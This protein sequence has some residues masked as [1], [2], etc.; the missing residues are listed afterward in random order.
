MFTHMSFFYVP[1]SM[2]EE[3][4]K[5]FLRLLFIASFS[6]HS[7]MTKQECFLYA[8][9]GKIIDESLN[10]GFLV[11]VRKNNMF[12]LHN[13]KE[14]FSGPQ[15]PNIN[16]Q[17]YDGKTV[18]MIATKND[19]G[20]V[21][22]FLIGLG[23][24][25]NILDNKGKTALMFVESYTMGLALIMANSN[26]RVQDNEGLTA[27]MIV[28][29]Y[30][31]AIKDAEE[32]IKLLIARGAEVEVKN[33]KNS[34]KTAEDYVEE[35]SEAWPARQVFVEKAFDAIDAGATLRKYYLGQQELVKIYMVS[36]IA[37]II[38]DYTFGDSPSMRN[39]ILDDIVNQRLS[40]QS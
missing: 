12:S 25:P 18:L 38:G 16:A 17:D 36:D 39:L 15:I 8:R 14:L 33:E 40:Q 6:L 10:S 7:A 1:M 35:I 22:K 31:F 19:N 34:N 4:M 20:A 27:L 30:H 26:L 32:I 13:I 21:V 5:Q 24:D 28:C 3:S 37:G 9:Q 29:K 11:A 2:K 23:A